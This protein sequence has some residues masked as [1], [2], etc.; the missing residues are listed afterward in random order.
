MCSIAVYK[1][2]I[3]HEFFPARGFGAARLSVARKAIAN[4]RKLSPPPASLADL[5]LFY[6]ETGVQYTNTYG[7][8][9]ATFY[10]SME[11]MFQRAARL[12]ART[13]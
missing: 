2:R 5:M 12:I 7:D 1:A 9:N 6:V 3:R 10:R 11:T 8:I 4:Y 13:A